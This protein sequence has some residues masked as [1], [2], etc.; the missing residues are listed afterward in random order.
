MILETPRLILRAFEDRDRDAFAALV[1]DPEVMR[2]FPGPLSRAQS[3][4]MIDRLET[5]RATAL[6]AFPALE[7]KATG[8]CIGFAG[9]NVST[10]PDSDTPCVEIGWRLARAAWGRGYATEAARA[11]LVR[12]FAPA[13]E[14]G[15]ALPEIVAYA[16]DANAPSRAVM[17]RL[18][19]S[20]D[21][22]ADFEL[23][24]FPEGHPHRPAVLYRLRAC[25]FAPGR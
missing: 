18:G 11:E 25:D 23:D 12:G 17:D 19:M 2:Y 13:E 3:D 4:G 14:G 5:R 22:A 21:P 8:E 10:L 15:L 16:V 9:L 7:L 24:E 1:A 20:R 6:A